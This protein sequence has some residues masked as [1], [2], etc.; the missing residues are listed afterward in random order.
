MASR[1]SCAPWK[2]RVSSK[3]GSKKTL[4]ELFHRM[5]GVLG[6]DAVVPG[7]EGNL[8]AGE[9][10][11]LDVQQ[12]VFQVLPEAGRSPVLDGEAGPFGDLVSSL[13]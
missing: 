10:G 13:P 2:N 12:A 1:T 8:Q 7:E 9:T 11:R 5:A 4:F 3:S 6:L